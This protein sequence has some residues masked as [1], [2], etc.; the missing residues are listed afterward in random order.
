MLRSLERQRSF[1]LLAQRHGRALQTRLAAARVAV[2]GL[3]GL[4]SHVA[5]ALARAGL[6]GLH[7]ID[8][9]LVDRSNLHRQAY[10]PRHLGLP[11]T[12]ALAEMLADIN[13]WLELRL[14]RVRLTAENIPRLLAGER[15]V[16]EALDD[17]AAKAELVGTALSVFPEL[18]MVG[19]SGLA[20]LGP[21]DEIVTRR[22]G[23]RLYLCGD[24]ASEVRPGAGLLCSRVMVC[25]G[26]QAHQVIRLLMEEETKNE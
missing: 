16:V 26:Q 19:A 5:L 15:I 8:F 6:G 21:A 7:L 11:K 12:E 23:R 10:F 24:A 17:P 4:G 1:D 22:F 2:A 18:M 9:D 3:G 25:A 14:S 20:G 13:P